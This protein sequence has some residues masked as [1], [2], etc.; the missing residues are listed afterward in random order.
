M[1]I[2]MMHDLDTGFLAATLKPAF[3]KLGHDC[4]VMQTLKTYLEK[5]LSLVNLRIP[6]K[7]LL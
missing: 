6:M 4:V 7:H 3:E 5:D 1:K 2:V